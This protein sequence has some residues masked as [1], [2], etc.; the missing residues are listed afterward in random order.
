MEPSS[1]LPWS[2]VSAV[3]PCSE[4]VRIL[5]PY[6]LRPILILF[7][8]VLLGL[9]SGHEMI[10]MYGEVGRMGSRKLL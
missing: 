3:G 9:P 2:Q 8:P 4:P 6:I 5:P 7:S 10:N 1:L